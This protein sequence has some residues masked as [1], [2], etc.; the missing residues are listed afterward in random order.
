MAASAVQNPA[1]SVD[2]KAGKK[3]KV[4]AG[5]TESPAPT[6][7]SEKATSVA[8]NGDDSGEPAYLRDLSKCVPVPSGELCLVKSC[9]IP[10]E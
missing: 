9:E 4:K 6:A 3:K 1:A 5:R 10:R 7:P 8:P 2:A